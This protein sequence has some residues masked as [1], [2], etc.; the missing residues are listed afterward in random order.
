MQTT[1]KRNDE[2][3]WLVGKF[4]HFSWSFFD[5][6]VFLFYCLRIFIISILI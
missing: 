3:P 2:G 1:R 5:S 4:H 6:G